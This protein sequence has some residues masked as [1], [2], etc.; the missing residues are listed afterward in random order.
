MQLDGVPQRQPVSFEYDGVFNVNGVGYGPRQ[1]FLRLYFGKIC[2]VIATALS[3]LCLPELLRCLR[4]PL[5]NP[6]DDLRILRRF[7]DYSVGV[8]P[9]RQTSNVPL[10]SMLG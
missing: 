10:R 1:E 8:G 7:C 5:C 9:K 6:D 2:G 4:L 3:R